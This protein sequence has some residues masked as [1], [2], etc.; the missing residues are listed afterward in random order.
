M[1]PAFGRS[2][3][4]LNDVI[5]VLSELRQVSSPLARSGNCFFQFGSGLTAWWTA[6]AQLNHGLEI[7][8]NRSPSRG[9]YSLT[10]RV[11]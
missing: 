3:Y 8:R 7:L 9:S 1:N 10:L 11:F 5:D 4:S 6:L 2:S